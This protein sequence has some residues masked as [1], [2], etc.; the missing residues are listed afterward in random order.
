MSPISVNLNS[1]G[2]REIQSLEKRGITASTRPQRLAV[3]ISARFRAVIGV[4]PRF[5]EATAISCGD[6]GGA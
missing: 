4:R 6:H 1:C 5:N 3:E 2:D